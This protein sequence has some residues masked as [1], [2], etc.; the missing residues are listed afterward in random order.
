MA[1]RVDGVI[2]AVRYSPVGQ[3]ELVRIHERIGAA[4][5]DHV[6]MDRSTLV[7][8]LKSGKR[9]VLGQ[10]QVFMGGTFKVGARVRVV[11]KP[12]EDVVFT[13]VQPQHHDELEGAPLF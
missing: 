5:S 8:S 4:F 6:L 11:G 1:Q 13:G 9:F 10:R 12:G 7:Q 2:E 3:I